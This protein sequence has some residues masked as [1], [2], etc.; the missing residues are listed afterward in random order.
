MLEPF[1]EDGILLEKDSTSE[2]DISTGRSSEDAVEGAR[3]DSKDPTG[4][5][6]NGISVRDDAEGLYLTETNGWSN[7]QVEPNLQCPFCK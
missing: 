2:A 4:Y 5:G 1:P 3:V 7:L 6:V